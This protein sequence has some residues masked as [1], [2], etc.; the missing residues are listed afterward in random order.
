[1]GVS[2]GRLIDS[3]CY[4]TAIGGNALRSNSLCSEHTAVGYAALY[5]NTTGQSNTAVGFCS[6]ITNET[7]G[8]NVS[9]GRYVCVE[10]PL[11]LKTQLLVIE[12]YNVILQV[13][14]MLRTEPH[15]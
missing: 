4:N 7:G 10:I 6:L 8:F 5:S 11:A 13:I 12:L 14:K 15:L 1:M 2:A 3:G 9:L